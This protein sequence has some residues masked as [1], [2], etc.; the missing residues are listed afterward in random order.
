[1]SGCTKAEDK[2]D[3]FVCVIMPC[4]CFVPDIQVEKRTC[5]CLLSVFCVNTVEKRR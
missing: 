1:M 5:E 3:A 4:L 2:D